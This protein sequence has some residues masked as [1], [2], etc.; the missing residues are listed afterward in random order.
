MTQKRGKNHNLYLMI[1][2]N[3][4]LEENKFINKP[5]TDMFREKHMIVSMNNLIKKPTFAAAILVS[6]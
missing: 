2:Q 1:V 4:E 6:V 3:K 5:W